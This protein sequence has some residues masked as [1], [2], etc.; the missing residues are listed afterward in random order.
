[1]NNVKYS[2]SINMLA[3]ACKAILYFTGTQPCPD[4]DYDV[5][6]ACCGV[7]ENIL[8]RQVN[9]DDG[10][11]DDDRQFENKSCQ[12]TSTPASSA[13]IYDLMSDENDDSKIVCSDIQFCCIH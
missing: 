6:S 11:D 13:E 10:V 7:W 8:F 3:Y 4:Y 5:K 1:M 2:D 12:D 9:I